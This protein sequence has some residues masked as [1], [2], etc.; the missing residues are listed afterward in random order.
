MAG[1]ARENGP[2]VEC[3]VVGLVSWDG[4][5]P[6]LVRR[7]CRVGVECSEVETGGNEVIGLSMESK[8]NGEVEARRLDGSWETGVNDD[9]TTLD[10]PEL[11]AAPPT[12]RADGDSGVSMDCGCVLGDNGCCCWARGCTG[13]AEGKEP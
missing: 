9:W 6:V 3:G 5:G 10:G 13:R 2:D 7:E 4:L 8:G 11:L 1:E 12:N